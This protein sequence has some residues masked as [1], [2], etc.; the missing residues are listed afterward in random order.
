M[1]AQAQ[2][3]AHRI[4]QT[5]DVHIYRL[6]TE[7]TIEENI[8]MKANQKRHL[9]K[10][11]IEDGNY[12]LDAFAQGAAS[13]SGTVRDVLGITSKGDEKKM[14][15]EEEA[16]AM[17]ML[18]DEE[19]RVATQRARKEARHDMVEFDESVPLTAKRSVSPAT[20]SATPPQGSEMLWMQCRRPI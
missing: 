11:S 10:L 13:D 16:S 14:T 20:P 4:G 5:R 1:D 12:T 6:I 3:R 9:N 7:H 17:A 8:L 19:D 18:E 2:D 15:A